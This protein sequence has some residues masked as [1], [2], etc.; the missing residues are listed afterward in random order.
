M[1]SPVVAIPTRSPHIEGMTDARIRR[2]DAPAQ[3]TPE[4]LAALDRKA[5]QAADGR[6]AMAE[7]ERDRQATLNRMAELRAQRLAQP[8]PPAPVKAP[9]KTAKKAARP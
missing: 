4:R 7:Y 2:P 1:I 5:A 9:A 3:K 8:R 6:K